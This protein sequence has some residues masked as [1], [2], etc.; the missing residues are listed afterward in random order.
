MQSSWKFGSTKRSTQSYQRLTGG[1][2][3]HNKIDRIGPDAS[4]VEVKARKDDP[5]G[6]DRGDGRGDSRSDSRVNRREDIRD[7]IREDSRSIRIV[8]SMRIVARILYITGI[9][10]DPGQRR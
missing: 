5:R 8:E 1:F 4:E 7:D 2:S 9:D 6:D 3:R 10:K